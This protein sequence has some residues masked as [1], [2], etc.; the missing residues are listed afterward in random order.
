MALLRLTMALMSL[1]AAR[2][3]M[4]RHYGRIAAC[5]LIYA[6]LEAPVLH[7]QQP[8]NHHAALDR[9]V[10]LED[11]A[12]YPQVFELMQRGDLQ[13][14]F[15]ALHAEANSRENDPAYFNLVGALALKLRDYPRAA[16]AFERVVLM[17]PDNAGAW[18]DLAIASAEG[19]QEA[20]AGN[21]F[22]HIE[23]SF[24][25]SP[26]IRAVIAAY[27]VRMTQTVTAP[28]GWKLQTEVFAGGDSNANSGL[29][30]R[31]IPLT[32]GADRIELPLDA[33]YRAHLDQFYQTSASLNFKQPL[34][35]N[36]IE[37]SANA[38]YRNYRQE[39]D[40]STLEVSLGAGM[41]HTTPVGDFGIVLNATHLSLGGKSLVRTSRATAQFEHDM[42]NCRVGV[43]G[44]SER[45]RY[46]SYETLDA[47]IAWVQAGLSCGWKMAKLPLQTTL[48]KRTGVDMPVSQ[49]PGGET[50]LSEWIAQVVAPLVWGIYGQFSY[51]AAKARDRDG[52]SPLL[53]QNA[54]RLIDRHSLRV[55]LTRSLPALGGE[56]FIAVESNKVQSNLPLFQQ[57]G[58]VVGVG[59]RKNM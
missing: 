59:F 16:V 45:R 36:L 43:G 42:N 57:A 1:M 52:Y 4:P 27:R 58:R 29:Q 33:T 28:H 26:G 55:A 25:P 19:G 49:R 54:A 2:P 9:S 53:E 13:A 31:S 5:G 40:Y 37:F 39:H 41:R 38:K 3:K 35:A 12:R 18:M 23:S 11:Y 22:D 10:V 56:A 14:A 24:A 51:A 6:C 50:R 32:V 34:E 48:L 7:A 30:N 44:E 46:I 15:D 47:N 17:Q 20:E 8:V 21:Y